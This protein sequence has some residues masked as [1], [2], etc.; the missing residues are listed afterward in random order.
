MRD[1]I[2]PI[3]LT[4]IDDCNEWL[5]GE[6]CSEE[7]INEIPVRDVSRTSGAEEPIFYTRRQGKNGSGASTHATPRTH[8]KRP[9]NTRR[10][11]DEDDVEDEDYGEECELIG[12]STTAKD[13]ALVLSEEEWVDYD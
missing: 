6:E 1:V 5:L 3:I 4:T 11:I 9:T 7:T 10:L 2:D 8:S 13:D 12:A